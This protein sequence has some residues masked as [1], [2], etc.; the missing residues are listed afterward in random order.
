MIELIFTI[1]I[2]LILGYFVIRGVGN[3]LKGLLFLFLAFLIYSLISSNF[4]I[5]TSYIGNFIK[6]SLEKIKSV[7]LKVEII[8]V[9]KSSNGNLI[10][11]IKNAG[12]LPIANP[13]VKI[14]GREVKVINNLSI[15]LPK[16]LAALELDWKESFKIIEVEA[17][18]AKAIY[19][20][21]SL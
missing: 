17:S 5:Q 14:D 3:I 15:L 13:S 1:L 21:S 11:V 12:Y 20:A 9:S 6:P 16:S 4:P 19:R 10:I 2:F 7:F 8:S 18:G